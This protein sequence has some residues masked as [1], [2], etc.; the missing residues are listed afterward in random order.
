MFEMEYRFSSKHCLGDWRVGAFAYTAATM[1]SVE[2]ATSKL[3]RAA[4]SGR[5]SSAGAAE[6][7]LTLGQ[8][9]VLGALMHLGP[10]QHD[11]WASSC[12]RG[13]HRVLANLERAGLVQRRRRNEGRR[14]QIV[15]LTPRG[16]RLIGEVFLPATPDP[17]D[18][19][20]RAPGARRSVPL[21][22]RAWYQATTDREGPRTAVASQPQLAARPLQQWSWALKHDIDEQAIPSLVM[23][24][25]AAAGGESLCHRPGH[26]RRLMSNMMVTS[27]GVCSAASGCVVADRT[28]PFLPRHRHP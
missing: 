13:Q 10:L 5:R 26:G 6:A 9:G 16:R 7:G 17:P 22:A 3:M 21:R 11:C 19:G 8:F 12:G 27:T 2:R 28:H 15:S 1:S 14:V 25:S 23:L 4:D 18:G 24:G 20:T